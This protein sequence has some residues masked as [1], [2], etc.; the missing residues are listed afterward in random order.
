MAIAEPVTEVVAEH[1]EGPVWSA[2]WGELRWVDRLKGDVLGLAADGT[3]SRFHVGTVAAALRPRAAGG[4]VV[5][6]ERGFAL[7]SADGAIEPLGEVWTD[8]SVRMND[9]GC[10]PDGRFYCGTMAYDAA[11]NRGALYRLEL[12]LTVTEVFDGVTI[13]NGLVWSADG[14]H[15]YYVDTPTRRIDVFDYHAVGGLTRRRPLADLSDQNGS[16][17]GLTIDAEGHLW[18]AMHGGAAVLRVSPEGAVEGKID[19][20]AQHVTACTFGGPDLDELYITTS[21]Y[22]EGGRQ[23]LAGALFRADVGVRGLEVRPFAG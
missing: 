16:P 18:V 19:L 13:S 20:P 17:D 4:M 14:A 22:E 12:D 8:D 15:A 7:V 10:D 2:D 9:G 11:P 1:A 6:V 21:R 23:P 3:V 5:A